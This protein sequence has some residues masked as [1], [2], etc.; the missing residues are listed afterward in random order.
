MTEFVS[1][2]FTY[3]DYEFVCGPVFKQ[4]SDADDRVRRDAWSKFRA[5]SV[6]WRFVTITIQLYSSISSL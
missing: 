3:L 6:I 4:D 2:S 5:E 1:A